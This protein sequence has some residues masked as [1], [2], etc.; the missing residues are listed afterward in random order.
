MKPDVVAIREL[1]TRGCSFDE[2]D[3]R[4]PTDRFSAVRAAASTVPVTLKGDAW[5]ELSNA[6]LWLRGVDHN[7]RCPILSSD[8]FSVY[9][10]NEFSDEFAHSGAD[11]SPLG[12]SN[13]LAHR[14]PKLCSVIQADVR[15]TRSW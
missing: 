14:F 4:P 5:L 8:Q 10:P 7:G 6:E 9:Q 3:V 15:T 13:E 2:R 11:R 12:R 1:L